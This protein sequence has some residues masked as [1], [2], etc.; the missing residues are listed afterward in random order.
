MK[1]TWL[2]GPAT[3]LVLPILLNCASPANA[4][5]RGELRRTEVAGIVKSIDASGRK[6]TLGGGEGRGQ[7]LPEKSFDLAKDVE[8][9]V[10]TGPSRGSLFK[11]AKL[12]DLTPGTRVGLLLAADGNTVE[13]IVT[14]GP[15]V[16]GQLVVIDAD[17]RTV[18]IDTQSGGR[19][20]GGGEKTLTVSPAAEIAIDNGKGSRFS[21]REA[22]LGDLTAGV[23]AT[24]WLSLDQKEATA[25]LAEAPT[26]VGAVKS[27]DP[28]TRTIVLTTRPPRGDEAAEEQTLLVP[29]DALVIVDDGRGRRLSAREAKLEDVPTGAMVMARLTMDRASIVQLRAE[30]PMIGGLLTAVDADKGTVTVAFPRGRGEDPEEKTFTLAKDARIN[31]DGSD[32]PL[33]SL[34]IGDNGTMLQLRLSLDQK[35]VHQLVARQAGSR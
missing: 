6:I 33:S 35:T 29:K 17:K 15:E 16:R 2:S 31:V 34:R 27:L 25:I 12:A 14:Q 26:V 13:S 4:Q 23:P 11:A 7:V 1:G 19:L 5:F 24:V 9:A 28:T 8:I 32:A 3:A 10:S 22:T 21:I 30:G 18:K 20:P